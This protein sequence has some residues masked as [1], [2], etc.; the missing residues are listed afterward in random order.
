MTTVDIL[1][2]SSQAMEVFKKQEEA[3]DPLNYFCKICSKRFVS[4]RALG[5]HMR[6]HA[7]ASIAADTL[8]ETEFQKSKR[9]RASDHKSMEEKD[10]EGLDS[11][12]SNLMYALRKN[13]KRSW[14]FCRSGLLVSLRS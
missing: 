10:E 3:E 14:R 12:G 5:G 7:P 4:G 8:T 1:Y 13:P 2:P 6:A 9:P 11:N